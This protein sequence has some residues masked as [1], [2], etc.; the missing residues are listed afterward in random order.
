MLWSRRRNSEEKKVKNRYFI[1]LVPPQPLFDEVMTFKY[2]F[3]NHYGSKSALNTPPH[4]TLRSPFEIGM[5]KEQVLVEALQ[6]LSSTLA[7][8]DIELKDFGCF[9]PHV[10]FIQVMPSDHLSQLQYR[11]SEFCGNELGLYKVNNETESSFHP[12][13]TIGFRDLTKSSFAFAWTEFEKKKFDGAF[14][15]EQFCLLKHDG[16]KW[17]VLKDFPMSLIL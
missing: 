16:K 1:A 14:L 7:H 10:I 12:H 13:M 15:A 3:K 9:S 5:E 11:I 6:Q 4:I 8:V 2:H 17:N